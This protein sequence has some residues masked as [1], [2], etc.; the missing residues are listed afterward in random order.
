M[1]NLRFWLCRL[2]VLCLIPL[3]TAACTY[4][5]AVSQ[6]NF[7]RERSKRVRAE[8]Q[9]YMIL[10]INFDNDYLYPLIDKLKD[11]CPN[12]RVRGLLTKDTLTSYLGIFFFSRQQLAEGYCVAESKKSIAELRSDADGGSNLSLAEPVADGEEDT[13]ETKNLEIESL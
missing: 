5:H 8:T 4:V 2:M 10:G 3:S 13:D 9:R 12:G 11:Q 7:P 6:T 1:S